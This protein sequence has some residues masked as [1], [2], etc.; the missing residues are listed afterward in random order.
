ME[1]NKNTWIALAAVLGIIGF[2]AGHFLLPTEVE[3]IVEVEV[4]PEPPAVIK[5]GC[6]IPLSGWGA[7]VFGKSGLVAE[8]LEEILNERGGIYIKKYNQR[9]PVDFIIYDDRSDPTIVVS[10]YERLITVDKVDACMGAVTSYLAISAST[11]AEKYGVP[12]VHQC[13]NDIFVY[14]QGNEWVA[15]PLVP[16]QDKPK[17]YF[18]M[19]AEEGEANTIAIVHADDTLF[20][21]LAMGAQKYAEEA[22]LEIVYREM[23][24]AATTDFTSVITHI[25]EVDPDIVYDAGF[26][27][28]FIKQAKEL[29]VEP[30][31]FYSHGS[32]GKPVIDGLGTLSEYMMDEMWTPPPGQELGNAE[33]WEEVY[34]RAGFDPLE[35]TFVASCYMSYE[36]LLEAL[37]RVDDYQDPVEIRDTILHQKYLTIGGFCSFNTTSLESGYGLGSIYAYPTQVVDGKPVVVAPAWAKAANHIYPTP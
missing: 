24:P 27:V 11:V 33:L 12:M 31:E 25:K 28:A 29:G 37:Q 3:K 5:I 18:E 34:T 14:S 22:G 30:R 15:C 23:L 17:F 26:G 16:I 8:T 4:E 10:N 20:T 2:A 9:C 32:S 6:S 35:Y 7:P 1:Y 36:V 21:G 19:L 13:A